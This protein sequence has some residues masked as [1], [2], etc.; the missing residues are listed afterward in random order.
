MTA[1]ERELCELTVP[2]L[3]MGD[4]PITLS[5]WLVDEDEQVVEG[6]RLVELLAGHATVDLPA[7]ATGVL[8]RHC[9]ETDDPVHVGQRIALITPE[10]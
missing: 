3:G 8:A 9:V 7:P 1:Q 2:D 5:M 4:E 10:S 6:D